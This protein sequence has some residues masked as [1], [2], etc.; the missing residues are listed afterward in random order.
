MNAGPGGDA[1]C[2][3][4]GGSE[5]V[6]GIADDKSGEWNAVYFWRDT[7]VERRSLTGE[8]FLSCARPAADG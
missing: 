3:F 2:G 5:R 8:L 4:Q 6:G 1:R 7:V